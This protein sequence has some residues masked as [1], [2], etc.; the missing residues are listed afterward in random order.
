MKLSL[1]PVHLNPNT[2]KQLKALMTLLAKAKAFQDASVRVV[3]HYTQQEWEHDFTFESLACG[4]QS[5]MRG[6]DGTIQQ[7]D[8]VVLQNGSHATRYQ[9]DEI[10]YDATLSDCWVA[11]LHPCAALE[12]D[13]RFG[14]QPM[15]KPCQLSN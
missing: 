4:K 7:G 15:N 3:H 9:V 2:L 14:M 1:D 5:Y 11:R 12:T 10:N 6:R 13:C 8:Y